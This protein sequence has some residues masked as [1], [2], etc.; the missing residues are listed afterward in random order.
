MWSL[1][2]LCFLINIYGK[3][4]KNETLFTYTRRIRKCIQK[5]GGY[6]KRKN[7]IIMMITLIV[8]VII[9]YYIASFFSVRLIEVMFFTGILFAGGIYYFSSSGGAM[10]R[11]FNAQVSGQMGFIQ[12]SERFT[13][14]V[15]P[16]FWASFIFLL[17]GLVLFILLITGVIPP[18]EM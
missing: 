13:V 7:L 16:V 11:F 14:K 5:G 3:N 4:Y 9:T 10:S 1:E 6:I 8:E 17:V 2:F 12:Q 18:Q 15:G